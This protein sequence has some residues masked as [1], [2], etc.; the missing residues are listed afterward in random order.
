VHAIGS[1]LGIGMGVLGG[2]IWPLALVPDWLRT[3]DHA[4]PQAWAV[5]TWTTLPSR[6]D[7]LSAIL[8]GLAVLA[9]FAT[10]L[11]VLAAPALRQRLT[12]IAG[13]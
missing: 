5:D 6:A 10:A 3:V 7:G 12:T 2:C 1:A 4:V 8:I 11:L 9:A 13:A